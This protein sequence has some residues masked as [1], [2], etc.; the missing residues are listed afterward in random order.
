[1]FN[2][3]KLGKQRPQHVLW[4]LSAN[5]HDRHL[6]QRRPMRKRPL[7]L[8]KDRPQQLPLVGGTPWQ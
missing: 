8:L 7:P 5:L 2:K 3:P 6:D 4:L 1:M